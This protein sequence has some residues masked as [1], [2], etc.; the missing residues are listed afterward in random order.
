MADNY[1]INPTQGESLE[2]GGLDQSNPA[3][4]YVDFADQMVR[5]SQ[6]QQAQA[7][8]IKQ[9]Q[10][11]TK[12]R[13]EA[14]AKGI[15]PAEKGYVSK[16]EA[17]ALIQAELSRQKLLSDDVKAQLQVW[18]DAAPQMVEQQDVKD[19]ISR[20][21]PKAAKNGAPFLATDQD[22]SDKDKTDETG[23]PL[24]EGQMYSAVTDADGNV[25]YERGGQEKVDNSGSKEAATSEKAW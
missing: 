2:A 16:D 7:E 14:N 4:T 17:M 15:N 11:L 3:M 6:A 23:K 20:Y 18:Y 9:A 13:T 21:Q 22:A 1:N 8:A 12:Q 24:V 10:L 25:T 5:N 19:F